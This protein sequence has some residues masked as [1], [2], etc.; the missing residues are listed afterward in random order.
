V[1]FSLGQPSVQPRRF[2]SKPSQTVP[3]RT[4][5]KKVFPSAAQP[6]TPNS[7]SPDRLSAVN[8]QPTGHGTAGH[9]RTQGDTKI[10]RFLERAGSKRHQ[11]AVNG[12]K[13]VFS[14]ALL[15]TDQ[16]RPT[17]GFG[18]GSHS[19][20]CNPSKPRTC[21]T[22]KLISG[23]HPPRYFGATGSIKTEEPTRIYFS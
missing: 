2:R 20:T 5:N 12:T 21:Y 16:A 18:F 22:R 4:F 19:S 23:V 7:V 17:F 6:S 13:K 14:F 11:T 10:K 15:S 3:N 9:L 8:P 1:P